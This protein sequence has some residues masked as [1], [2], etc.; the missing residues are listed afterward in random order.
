MSLMVP[1]ACSKTSSQA[2]QMQLNLL[3]T[4]AFIVLTFLNVTTC[5]AAPALHVQEEQIIY[6][7]KICRRAHEIDAVGELASAKLTLPF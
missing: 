5:C 3:Q 4:D 1:Y 2:E 6:W 7:L